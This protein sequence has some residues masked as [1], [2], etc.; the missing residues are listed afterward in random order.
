MRTHISRRA[1]MAVVVHRLRTVLVREVQTTA[2][3]GVQKCG[4]MW[5]CLRVRLWWARLWVAVGAAVWMRGIIG[6]LAKGLYD[7]DLAENADDRF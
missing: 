7:V 3:Y 4:V 6:R 2:V 5:W 1:R